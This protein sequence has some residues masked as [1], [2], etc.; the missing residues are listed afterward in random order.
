MSRSLRVAARSLLT[1]PNPA[2]LRLNDALGE[3]KDNVKYLTTLEKSFEPLYH[4]NPAAILEAVPA[5][6]NN[7]KMLHAIA[8]YYGTPERMTVLF[9]KI[10]QQ[11][12][13]TCRAFILAPGKLYDQDKPSL[14]SNLQVR[15]RTHSA[16][17]AA[18]A[19]I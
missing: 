13:N 10:T 17:R 2:L 11:M 1:L 16:L 18:S 7:I 12:I 4:D 6:M 5:M 14:I 19:R 15:R 3:S 9:S 8:R